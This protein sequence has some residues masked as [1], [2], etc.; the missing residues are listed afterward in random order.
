MEKCV[1]S[2]FFPNS[3]ATLRGSTGSVKARCSIEVVSEAFGISPCKFPNKMALVKCPY[4][5]SVVMS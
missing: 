5:L 3:V 1:F 2:C 4:D